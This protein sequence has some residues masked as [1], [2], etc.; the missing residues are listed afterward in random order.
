MGYEVL[1]CYGGIVLTPTL[2][3]SYTPQ[4]NMIME[5]KEYIKPSAGVNEMEPVQM[6]AA[7]AEDIPVGGDGQ[8]G[9]EALSNRHR[10]TWGNLWSEDKEK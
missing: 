2:L 10:G 9:G 4:K 6:I 1:W 7:S 8:G 3:Y 5:K